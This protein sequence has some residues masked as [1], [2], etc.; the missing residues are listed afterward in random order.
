MVLDMKDY[1][2]GSTAPP[3]HPWCRTVTCPYFDDNYTRRAARGAD[4]EIYYV[5]GKMT[6]KEW[7]N[8]LSKADQDKMKL[9]L[10][11]HR[12]LSRDKEQHQN[13]KKVLGEEMPP[14]EKFRDLKYNNPNTWKEMQAFYRQKNGGWLPDSMKLALWRDNLRGYNWQAVDFAPKKIND[15]FKRHG[16]DFG[17]V[18]QEQYGTMAKQLLNNSVEGPIDGFITEQGYVFR[19][20]KDT[21]SFAIGKP[22]GV[23]A[24]FY[25]PTGG[26]QYWE[27]EKKKY[28]F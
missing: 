11:K 20:D 5:D 10:N 13:Y 12:N 15:H 9:D 4:G 7:W 8:S 28:G 22:D 17:A 16:A 26:Q 6:Y 21:N 3:F 1:A 14:F 25:K 27:R 24:T 2:P 19:Y 18:S 23:I